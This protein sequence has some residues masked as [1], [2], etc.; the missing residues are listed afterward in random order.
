MDELGGGDMEVGLMDIGA[1]ILIDNVDGEVEAG[2]GLFEPQL[3]SKPVLKSGLVPPGHID[4]GE[5]GS[6]GGKA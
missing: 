6:I 5:A 3:V 1:G 4:F 2:A